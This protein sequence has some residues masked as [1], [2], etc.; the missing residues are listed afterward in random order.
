MTSVSSTPTPYSHLHSHR[1]QS[2]SHTPGQTQT[3]YFGSRPTPNQ[4]RPAQPP[5]ILMRS[6]STHSTHGQGRGSGG[7]QQ[8]STSL[9][10]SGRRSISASRQFRDDEAVSEVDE[11]NPETSAAA[12]VDADVD[13]DDADD[14]DADEEADADESLSA[15]HLQNLDL[16]ARQSLINV[17]HPFGLPIWKPALYKKSRSVTRYADEA[18]H[19]IPSAKREKEERWAIGNGNWF[20]VVVFGWWMA[21][22]VG[23][24]GLLLGVGEGVGVLLRYIAK[25]FRTEKDGNGVEHGEERGYTYATLTLGLAWY[26]FWPFGK[27][28]EGLVVDDECGFD[29]YGA[30]PYPYYDDDEDG[31]AG[32]DDEEGSNHTVRGGVLRTSSDAGTGGGSTIRGIPTSGAGHQQTSSWIPTSGHER[33]S[34]LP[35]TASAT[36]TAT[37]QTKSYGTISIPKSTSPHSSGSG[38][39]SDVHASQVE[40]LLWDILNALDSLTFHILFIVVIA[41]LLLSVSLICWGLVLTIPMAKLNWALIRF[42]TLDLAVRSLLL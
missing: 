41:P 19:S 25:R 13:A 7:R 32:D 40:V 4:R 15:S 20:W 21:L 23:S 30:Y 17:Q 14:I 39:N 6:S 3:S 22:V 18:L 2:Q 28:V 12:D 29:E 27:Y 10:S 26:L 8:R 11:G 37:P 33:T 16:K 38:L 1:S 34:L 9:S 42:V 36:A 24:L 31:E 35:T 5:P